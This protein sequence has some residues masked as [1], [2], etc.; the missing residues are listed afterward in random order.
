MISKISINAA[1]LEIHTRDSLRAILITQQIDGI[2]KHRDT[3]SL[4]HYLS[5]ISHEQRSMM[6][7]YSSSA[8]DL[9]KTASS[10]NEATSAAPIEPAYPVAHTDTFDDLD[11]SDNVFMKYLTKLESTNAMAN[12][13]SQNCNPSSFI[14]LETSFLQGAVINDPSKL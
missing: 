14:P 12:V 11:I 8:T 7:K 6:A 10:Y 1:L 9:P 13:I 5:G 4:K 3:R 2:I